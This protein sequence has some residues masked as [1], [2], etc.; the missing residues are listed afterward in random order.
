MTLVVVVVEKERVRKKYE[1][2][3][4]RFSPLIMI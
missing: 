2:Q 3:E 4:R 1:T